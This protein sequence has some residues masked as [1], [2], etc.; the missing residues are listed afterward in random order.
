M[1][2]NTFL[3]RLSVLALCL[4]LAGCCA[5][6][7]CNCKDELADALFFRFNYTKKRQ[8]TTVNGQL[9]P[10]SF[11]AKDIDTIR[12]YRRNNLPLAL[13]GPGKD[14]LGFVRQTDSVTVVRQLDTKTSPGDTLIAV[15]VQSTA[16]NGT[17]TNLPDQDIIVINNASPFASSSTTKLNAYTYRIALVRGRRK[18]K[19][20]YYITGIEL[21]GRYDANGCCTCYENTKKT[22]TLT[23]GSTREY[24]NAADSVDKRRIARLRFQR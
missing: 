13:Q 17:V 7:V 9:V 22:D 1:L 11:N 19:P 20:I 12:I 2:E 4:A 14:T 3:R 23:T 15:T 18:P 21:N 6:D 16:A 24:I 10:T 5:N 8:Y